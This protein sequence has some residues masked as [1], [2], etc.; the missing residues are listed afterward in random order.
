M[1]E[2]EKI[3]KLACHIRM[4]HTHII[5]ISRKIMTVE[6]RRNRKEY[7]HLPQMLVRITKGRGNTA[8]ITV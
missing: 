8:T 2:G 7:Q 3:S 6:T 5:H 1:T 4:Y